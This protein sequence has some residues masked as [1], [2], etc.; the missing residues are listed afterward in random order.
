[1]EIGAAAAVPNLNL[2]PR[3]IMNAAVTF[4]T[5]RAMRRLGLDDSL[6]KD[7]IYREACTVGG[8]EDRNLLETS[9]E[10]FHFLLAEHQYR[11]RLEQMRRWLRRFFTYLEVEEASGVA[12]GIVDKYKTAKVALDMGQALDTARENHKRVLKCLKRRAIE[13]HIAVLIPQAIDETQ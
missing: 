7:K 8:V 9:L 3:H 6:D 11:A 1:M 2:P 13:Y 5:C 10:F 12:D 4:F